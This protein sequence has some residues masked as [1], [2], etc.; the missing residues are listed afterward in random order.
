MP[1]LFVAKEKNTKETMPI[2]QASSGSTDASDPK[3]HH[4]SHMYSTFVENPEDVSF[5]HQENDEKII[6]FLR[7]HFITNV[8]WILLTLILVLLPIFF[9]LVSNYLPFPSIPGNYTFVLLSIYYLFIFSFVFYKFLNWY[10][11]LWIATNK[12]L[13]D[14]DFADLVFHDV[15]E[16]RYNLIQ[17][18]NYAQ[19]GAIRSFFNYGDV[20]AQTAGGKENLEA[21]GVPRPLAAIKIITELMHN[22]KK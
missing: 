18:V 17:D 10:Y 1:D 3:K 14:I 4:T 2:K 19:T 12:R 13:I 8:P 7:R 22:G 11:N 9:P 21:L 20:F 16:T 15:A 5:H 6:L